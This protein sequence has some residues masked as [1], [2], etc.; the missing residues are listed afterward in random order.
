VR[1]PVSDLSFYDPATGTPLTGSM[2][3]PSKLT[4]VNFNR[5]ASGTPLSVTLQS[6]IYLGGNFWDSVDHT[7]GSSVS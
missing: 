4:Q 1:I 6:Q 3:A 5:P 7:L 2:L